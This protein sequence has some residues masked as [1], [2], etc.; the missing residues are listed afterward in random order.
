MSSFRFRILVAASQKNLITALQ[1]WKKHFS[2][3]VRVRYG[4]IP[5]NYAMIKAEPSPFYLKVMQPRK[6][7]VIYMKRLSSKL[8]FSR[9]IFS[10]I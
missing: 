1:N 2:W 9:L 10:R 6:W 7:Y 3:D 8:L 4:L 5:I